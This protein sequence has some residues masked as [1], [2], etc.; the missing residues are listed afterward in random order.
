MSKKKNIVFSI[1]AILVVS[2]IVG[3]VF[4]LL[5]EGNAPIDTEFSS[6]WDTTKTSPGSSDNNQIK[7]PLDAGGTYNFFVDW[8]DGT[9]DTITSWNQA[10]VTHTYATQGVYATNITGTIIGW[11]F[12]DEGDKL[13][14][15]EIKQWGNL[16]LGN[17]GGYFYGCS[18]LNITASDILNLIGTTSLYGAFRECSKIGKVEGMDEW[19]VSTVTNMG[20]MFSFATSFNQDISSWD[21]SSVTTMETMFHHADSFNQSISSWDVSSVTN[22]RTMFFIATSFNQDIGS[23]DVSSVTNM[24]YMFSSAGSF[25][26]D[27]GS[28]DVSS[29]TDMYG[30][31]YYATSFN[32]NIGSWNVS[33]VTTMGT[34]FT[35]VTLSTANYDSL[36]MGWA[37]LPTLQSGVSFH[38]GNSQYSGGAAAAR[39]SL[40]D[41]PNNWIIDDGGPV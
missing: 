23:W 29:V 35:G 18:N 30:M 19:D 28:W 3:C 22:V 1:I 2:L 25:N 36:L 16:R 17:S 13:K 5:P 41:A 38:G 15:L 32:Q 40:L 21:V 34:M 33:S 9:N 4:L 11:R 20:Y 39:Q 6:R 37:S 26:Q 12:S 31:F 27:I 10:E 8:G 24:G 14:L 7:L